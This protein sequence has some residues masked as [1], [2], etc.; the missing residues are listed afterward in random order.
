MKMVMGLF[1]MADVQLNV[2]IASYM[3]FSTEKFTAIYM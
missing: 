3:N 1:T 2:P